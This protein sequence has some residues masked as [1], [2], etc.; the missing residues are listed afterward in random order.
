MRVTQGTFSFLPDFT[1]EE[2]GAQI[3][4][5]LSHGWAISIEHT[6]DPHPRSLFWELWGM[7]H[8]DTTVEDYDDVMSEVRAAREAFP[9]H[10]IKVSAY[11]PSHTRQTTAL[12]FFVHRPS[13][14]NPFKLDRV[15]GPGRTIHYLVLSWGA[16]MPG[17]EGYGGEEETS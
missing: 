1:D 12:S 10:R 17:E 9:D 7:P 3:R 16:P 14:E 2:V 11:D 5:A 13:V 6:E 8:V 15:V 4:Y